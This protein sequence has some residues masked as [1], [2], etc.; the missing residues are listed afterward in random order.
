LD[1]TW[2]EPGTICP[3]WHAVF[4]RVLGLDR[5]RVIQV[6]QVIKMPKQLG[7]TTEKD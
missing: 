3:L 2:E 7:T 5:F 1:E 4:K 6:K